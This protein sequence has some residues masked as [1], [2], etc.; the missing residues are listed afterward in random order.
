MYTSKLNGLKMDK[1]GKTT[2]TYCCCNKHLT[3][4]QDK[5]IIVSPCYHIFHRKCFESFPRKFCPLCHVRVTSILTEDFIKANISLENKLYNQLAIDILSLKP[6]YHYTPVSYSQS[7][8]SLPR[9]LA[10]ILELMK[11]KSFDDC[12]ELNKRILCDLNFKIK[13]KGA[14]LEKKQCVFIG[15]HNSFLD[16]LVV[17]YLTKCKFLGSNVVL[18]GNPMGEKIMKYGPLITFTRGKEKAM[19]K[20]INF[21]KKSNDSI[22]I[23]PEG[24]ITHPKTIGRFRSGAFNLGIPVQPIIINYNPVIMGES[25]NDFVIKL[26]SQKKVNVEVIV[27]PPF[28]PPFSEEKIEI[29]RKRMAQAGKLLLSRAS[30]RDIKD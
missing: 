26:A 15:N 21:V 9:V 6:F 1:L 7:L 22:C 2:N 28:Y 12:Y 17:Y 24:M 18:K 10:R 20:L 19:D 16:P 8:I 4:L 14:K 27:L 5:Y 13:L 25:L 29:V 30:N 3:F 23:F 11:I